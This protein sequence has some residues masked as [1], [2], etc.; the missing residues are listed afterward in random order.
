MVDSTN[1]G[2][3]VAKEKKEVKTPPNLKKA[4]SLEALIC[5]GVLALVFGSLG[6][7]M[8]GI[9]MI[10]TM[11]NTAYDLL[12]NTAFYILAVAVLAGA[13]SELLTE[14]GIIAAA[15]KILSP[16]IKPIFGLPGASAIG[17]LTTY[18]SDNPAILT[19]GNNPQIRR[20]FKK[21][22]LPAL[23]NIGTAFGMGLI[24]S[25]AVAGMAP[26][27][28]SYVSAVLVGNLGAI[29]GGLVST[30]IMLIFSAK[31]YGKEADC[32]VDG[33]EDFD[34]LEFREVRQGGV[35]S[36]A[37]SAALE[38]GAAG[39][40]LG[41]AVIPGILIIT[42]LVLMLTNGVGAEGVYSGAAYQG[43]GLL[44]ALGEKINFILQPL[45]GF[46]NVEAIAVPLTALGA[47][48]AA[49]G[50]I[51]DMIARGIVNAHDIAVFVSMC[52]CFSGYLCTHV[53]MMESLG[54]QDLTFHAI[55][56]HTIGGI[57]AG[58]A[59]HLIFTFFF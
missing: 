36:R 52:M 13:L 55:L 4:M 9:N 32:E 31:K 50:I 57:C 16:I 58:V 19:F 35:G 51:P 56:S 1:V 17:I 20:Y 11:I 5:L 21:Y 8:G 38:G 12:F 26:P 22:Q 34:I 23:T 45:F 47:A 49:I 2:N 27:G 41:M 40:Q 37:M 54:E 33:A 28:E 15:N 24:V 39:V 6:R 3:E 59:A 48:G 42:T 44:P 29:I 18:L 14:F 30:R 25:A 43:I 46:Q 10:N 7:V 53:V